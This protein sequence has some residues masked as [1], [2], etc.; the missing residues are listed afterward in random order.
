MPRPE[1]PEAPG[2]G[3]H[4]PSKT[5]STQPVPDKAPE[6]PGLTAPSPSSAPTQDAEQEARAY[7]QRVGQMMLK[8]L[9]QGVTAEPEEGRARP[10][11]K[12]TYLHALR[13]GETCIVGL[14]GT[15][16]GLD[17]QT[18]LADVRAYWGL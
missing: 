12:L 16:E 17:V 7:A 1:K 13:G 14:G 8:D 6:Q 3:A 4:P 2:I 15:S 11:V 10:T 9:P 5:E 18:A